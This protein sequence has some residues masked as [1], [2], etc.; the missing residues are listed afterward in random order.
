MSHC[1]SSRGLLAFLAALSLLLSCRSSGCSGDAGH[2]SSKGSDNEEQ[3]AAH[4]TEIGI[5]TCDEYVSKVGKC[6][7]AHAP[8]DRKEALELSLK[9]TRASWTALAANPGTRSSLDQTCELALTSIKASFS[10][11]SCEW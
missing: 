9:Q 2:S 6:I 3:H 8:Q 10:S 11:L 7:S 5:A 1:R 4:R